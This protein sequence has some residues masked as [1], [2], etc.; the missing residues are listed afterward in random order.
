M[1]LNAIE[2]QRIVAILYES[3]KK[4]DLL[5]YISTEHST[6]K[7]ELSDMVNDEISRIIE[8]QRRLQIKYEEL[9]MQRSMLKNVSNKTKYKEIQ[10]EIEETATALRYA[11]KVLCRNLKENP[12]VA[13][14]ISKVNYSH[15]RYLHSL[16]S[17]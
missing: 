2:T 14:N 13:E 10:T 17:K 8:E 12:D 15:I 4:L 7:E 9:I 11:T 16:A 1:S 6:R 3:L 5:D